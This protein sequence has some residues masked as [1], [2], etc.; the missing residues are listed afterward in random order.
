M[1]LKPEDIIGAWNLVDTFRENPDGTRTQHQGAD[2]MGI[3]M[4]TADG[5]M[6]AITRARS[7]P[8]PADATDADKARMFD[9]YLSYAGRW[10]LDGDTVTHHVEHALNENLVGKDCKRVID[11]QGDR[12]VLQGEG[13]AGGEGSSIATIIWERP[14]PTGG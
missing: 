10:S 2:P 13:G 11:H 4:Y 3:I 9:S 1:P 8:F 6:S 5:H 14:K 7:R 12:M